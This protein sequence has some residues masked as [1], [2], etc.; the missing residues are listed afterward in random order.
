MQHAGGASRVSMLHRRG[1]TRCWPS[2]TTRPR[3]PNGDVAVAAIV[4]SCV[5]EIS[6]RGRRQ[7]KKAARV[8]QSCAPDC[9]S[10]R[11]TRPEADWQN[12]DQAMWVGAKL[13][14]NYGPPRPNSAHINGQPWTPASS[15]SRSTTVMARSGGQGVAGSNPVS[16]T[17]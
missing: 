1:G 14:T 7:A 10:G 13:R 12:P 2:A 17:N 5:L 4:R 6:S 15:D 8:R 9:S 16:P 3:S 11:G